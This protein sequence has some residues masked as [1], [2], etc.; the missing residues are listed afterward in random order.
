MGVLLF[1]DGGDLK[2]CHPSGAQ[3]C[4]WG[5]IAPGVSGPRDLERQGRARLNAPELSGLGE[6]VENPLHLL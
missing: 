4:T 3:G 2:G 1:G 5:L 6:Q